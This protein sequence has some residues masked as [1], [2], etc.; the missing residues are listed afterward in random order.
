MVVPIAPSMMAMRF[1]SSFWMGCRFDMFKTGSAELWA[2]AFRG[3]LRRFFADCEHHFKVRLFGFA[4]GYFRGSDVQTRRREQV[5]H[6]TRG[7][8]GVALA[9]ARGHLVLLMLIEAKQHQTPARTQ[10]A[11]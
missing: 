9:V 3:Q 4:G 8:P 1:W 2:S 11:R 10:D 7:K 5:A 6:G